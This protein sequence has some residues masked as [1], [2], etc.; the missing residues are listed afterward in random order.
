MCQ[1]LTLCDNFFT[2]LNFFDKLL[3]FS[4][5]LFIVFLWNNFIH[6]L[7]I[8]RSI[9]ITFERFECLQLFRSPSQIFKIFRAH[10]KCFLYFS[11]FLHCLC[12]RSNT[13]CSRL[14][15]TSGP[16]DTISRAKKAPPA[17]MSTGSPLLIPEIRSQALPAPGTKVRPKQTSSKSMP[18]SLIWQ[19]ASIIFCMLSSLKSSF[20]RHIYLASLSSFS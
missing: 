11:T 6:C 1:S 19:A 9:N 2:F 17:I 15:Q 4:Y 20:H 8:F 14:N 18:P 7:A 12:Q 10:P 5:F 13:F 16:K 3:Y